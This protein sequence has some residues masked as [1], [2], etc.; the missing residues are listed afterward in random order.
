MHEVFLQ[1]LAAHPALRV[2]VNFEVFLSFDQDVSEKNLCL[3]LHNAFL[4]VKKSALLLKH[5][6]S[7]KN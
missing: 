4:Y 6:P 7:N 2:D 1:R 3:T 5:S